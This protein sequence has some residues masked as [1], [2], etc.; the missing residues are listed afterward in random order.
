MLQYVKFFHEVYKGL[1]DDTKKKQLLRAVIR[2]EARLNND[3]AT[4]ISKSNPKKVALENPKLY[5]Q[6]ETSSFDILSALGF[7]SYEVFGENE[8][9]GEQALL[10][11]DKSS[12]NLEYFA[13]RP[14]SELY[15]FYIRKAKLLAKLS[16]SNSIACVNIGLAR[17]IKNIEHATRFLSRGLK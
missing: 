15:E 14:K 6:F 3:I 9:P 17:R 7:S 4:V 13:G 8:F 2:A 11:L 1:E 10:K 12:N 16:Q 5:E